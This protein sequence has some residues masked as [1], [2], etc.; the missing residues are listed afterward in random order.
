MSRSKDS[1]NEN[2]EDEEGKEMQETRQ[3]AGK[4]RRSIVHASTCSSSFFRISKTCMYDKKGSLLYGP[5]QSPHPTQL[6]LPP[7]S[8]TDKLS[9]SS[10]AAVVPG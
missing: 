9:G 2:G 8:F 4:R 3:G 7:H 5:L 6:G 1:E 10:L